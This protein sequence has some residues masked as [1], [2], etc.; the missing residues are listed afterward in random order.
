MQRLRTGACHEHVHAQI[1]CPVDAAYWPC[2]L[3]SDCYAADGRRIGLAAVAAHDLLFGAWHYLDFSML[4]IAGLDG[5]RSLAHR[6]REEMI[7]AES[8][9]TM[10]EVRLEIDRLDRA[11][12]ALIAERSDY[13]A[14][15]ARIKADRASVR[16]DARIEDV[17]SKVTATAQSH[18][19]PALIVQSAYRALV[20]AS[21]AY[22]FERFDARGA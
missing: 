18:G 1:C 7:A 2:H 3:L 20:E 14:A 22:E 6:E 21:I 5:N 17:L 15:A 16:D 19:V 12:V 9:K 11:I 8:C 10:A 4:S 13:I